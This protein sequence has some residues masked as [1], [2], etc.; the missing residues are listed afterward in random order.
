MKLSTT[1]SKGIFDKRTSNTTDVW[2]TPP[3]IIHALGQ[4]DLDPCAPVN[5]HWDTALKHFTEKDDGLTAKWHGRVWLNPPYGSMTGKFLKRLSDHGNG[6]ALIFAR[7]DTRYFQEY[8][9]GCADAVFF[10][11]GR[12]RF[13]RQ[14]GIEGG[15]SAAPSCLIAYGRN[16]IA[17]IQNSGLRGHLIDIRATRREWRAA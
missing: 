5:R 17:S 15:S 6:I 16:N 2:L 8:V 14:D 1:K 3:S 9:F 13:F 7:T 4:F 12:I 11:R 10:F